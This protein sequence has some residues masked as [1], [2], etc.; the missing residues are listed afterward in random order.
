MSIKTRIKKRLAGFDLGTNTFLLLLAD[1][2][3]GRIDPVFEKETIVRLGQGVD[4]AGNLNAEAMQRG[5]A[6][7]KEYVTLVRQHRAEKIFAVGTSALR[8]AA[9]RME[10]LSAAAEKIGIHIEI[11]SGETEARLAFMGALSNKPNLLEPVA[12][13]DIGGGSTEV[14]IGETKHL[15]TDGENSLLARSADLGSVRLTERFL[16]H[17]PVQSEEVMHLRQHVQEVFRANWPPEGLAQVRTLVGTAGTIT[18]LAAMALALEEYDP[19]RI[20]NFLLSREKLGNL[21]SELMRRTIAER[22]RT[23]GLAPARAD[24]ILAGALI[25]DTFLDVYQ[26]SEILVSDRGLR[27]GVLMEKS[28]ETGRN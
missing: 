10:F 28:I 16:H 24:V 21:V 22:S 12:I 18:T 14:V 27:Y 20:D 1:V 17:D 11:I 19:R 2:D 15:W 6:C 25:L 23:P 4:A 9:N 5:L 13:L 3:S 26:F 8:D 7:L